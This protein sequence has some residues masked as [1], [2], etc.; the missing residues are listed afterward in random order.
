MKNIFSIVAFLI[1]SFPFYAEAT[2][3]ILVFTQVGCSRCEYTIESFKKNKINF[4]EYK[5]EDE[6]N[7]DKM[8]DVIS[9]SDKP[10]V[11]KITMPVIVYNGK[12]YYSIENLEAL[13]KKIS[14]K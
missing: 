7:N 11:E 12:V 4:I 8:W 2:S 14:G 9:E 1:I 5:T 10:D 6:A 13:I 3:E